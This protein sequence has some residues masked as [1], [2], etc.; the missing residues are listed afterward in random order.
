MYFPESVSVFFL[1]L[2]FLTH[3]L[4]FLFMFCFY[5]AGDM[6]AD[7]PDEIPYAIIKFYDVV[8]SIRRK[9]KLL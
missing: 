2:L 8:T 1:L 5:V 7:L 6:S 4:T 3:C 9:D